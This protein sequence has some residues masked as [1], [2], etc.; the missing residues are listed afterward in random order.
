MSVKFSWEACVPKRPPRL[1]K[2]PDASGTIQV[3]TEA[4]CCSTVTSTNHTNWRGSRHSFLICSLVTTTKLRTLPTLSLANSAIGMPSTGNAVCAPQRPHVEPPD[5]RIEQV[6][7]GGLLGTIQELL[8]VD[9]L[10]DAALVGAVGE[11]DAVALRTGGDRAVQPGWRTPG[12]AGLLTQQPKVAD[13]DGLGRVAE[14][15]DLGHAVDAPARHTRH[16]ISD[17]RVAFPPVLVRALEAAKAGDELRLGGIGHI[18]NLVCGVGEGAQH[19][20][21]VGIALRQGLAVADAHHL[22]PAL[23]RQ[24]LVAGKVDQ[25]F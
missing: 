20:D 13:L 22:R 25:V 16:Q 5:L 9:D 12:G 24:A 8:A 4:G 2:S 15:V 11:V 10:Q 17:A 1:Q 18:P 14:V 7:L 3:E 19:I 23:F 6:R 21:G